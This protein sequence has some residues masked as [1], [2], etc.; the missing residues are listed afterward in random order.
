MHVLK[1]A[2]L[3]GNS[4]VLTKKNSKYCITTMLDGSEDV[5]E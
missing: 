5:R 1:H 3:A 2:V 4:V